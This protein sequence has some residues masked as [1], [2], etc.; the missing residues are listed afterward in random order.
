M[1]AQKDEVNIKGT[2]V[3]FFNGLSL[4]NIDTMEYYST[5]D[6]HLLEV[7]MIWNLDTLIN[8]IMPLKNSNFQRINTFEF[9][10]I[11]QTK[12][13]AWVSYHNSALYSLDGKQRTKKWLESVVVVKRKGR[14]KI[15][16][17]H[18]TALE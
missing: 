6:F 5:T 2:I 12:K 9:I 4:I 11:N 3:G 18:S 10:R 16:M 14:W 17:M 13:T 1:F 15:Q 8:K 7:G